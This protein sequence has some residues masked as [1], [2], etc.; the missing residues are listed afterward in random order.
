MSPTRRV[1]WIRIA[2][3]V[4]FVIA[5][6]ATAMAGFFY[7]GVFP[8]IDV[9]VKGVVSEVGLADFYRDLGVTLLEAVLGFIVG[10]LIAIVLSIWLGLKPFARQAVEPYIIAIG[11]TPKIIFLP[12]LFLLFG[13][14]I[15]SK[16]AKGALSAFF[17]VAISA[18]HGFL[19]I[20]P[21]LLRVGKSF[22]ITRW[23]MATKIYLPAMVGPVVVGARLGIAMSIIGVLAA[24]IS[25]SDVGI[26]YRLAQ[27]SDKFEIGS[28]YGTIILLFAV[29][30]AINSAITRLQR[31]LSRHEGSRGDALALE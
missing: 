3:L 8:T 29:A 5:W 30:I 23:Q 24:E 21:A 31:R 19:M 16:I 22:G 17:P 4:L 2:T 7:E 9:I 13:L 12:I 11:G 27:Y 28:M 1:L 15:E 14:G 10:S 18:T 26:G 6:Q 25:Y 20:P